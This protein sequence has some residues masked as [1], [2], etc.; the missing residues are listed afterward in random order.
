[1]VL[2][3]NQDAEGSEDGNRSLLWKYLFVVYPKGLCTQ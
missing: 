1:M 3:L 2:V